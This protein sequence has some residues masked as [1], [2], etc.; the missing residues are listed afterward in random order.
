MTTIE[1][2]RTPIDDLLESS[3]IKFYAKLIGDDCPI[4][5]EDKG[6]HTEDIGQFPRKTHIHG[7][8]WRAT[9]TRLQKEPFVVDYWNSYHDTEY[10][11][12]LKNRDTIGEPMPKRVHD[13]L[14]RHGFKPDRTGWLD[15]KGHKTIQVSAYDVLCCVQKSDPGTFEEFC[16]YF[17]YDPDSRKAEQCWRACVEEWHKYRRFFTTEEQDKLAD[18]AN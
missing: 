7:Q 5:C 9:F 6:K 12:L 8:H 11:W 16:G 17:S 1:Q 2:Y 18:L 14:T 13:M 3:G 15:R 4:F 10:N